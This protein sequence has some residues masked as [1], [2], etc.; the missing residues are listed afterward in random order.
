MTSRELQALVNHW[1]R[2][3]P[4][5]PGLRG[6]KITAR[7]VP[8]SEL[9]RDRDVYADVRGLI[10]QKVVTMRVC[11]PSDMVKFDRSLPIESAVCHELLHILQDPN[12]LLAN[13]AIFESSLN[14]I[15][16]V[17]TRNE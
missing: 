9:D 11:R 4:F 17:L 13:D 5:D 16:A 1:Q 6:W 10:D 3:A 15:A 12:E 8:A 7:F 14:A 2:R